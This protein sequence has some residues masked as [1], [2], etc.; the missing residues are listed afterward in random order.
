M[1]QDRVVDGM[2]V[3]AQRGHWLARRPCHQS[4]Y[5]PPPSNEGRGGGGET[6][7]GPDVMATACTLGLMSHFSPSDEGRS[8]AEGATGGPHVMARLDRTA[9]QQSFR[10]KPRPPPTHAPASKH[11]TDQPTPSSGHPLR[12]RWKSAVADGAGQSI[13]C[14]PLTLW[15]F[16]EHAARPPGRQGC[17][18]KSRLNH[19][20]FPGVP[21]KSSNSNRSEPV[22]SQLWKIP[23]GCNVLVQKFPALRPTLPK[24]NG[25]LRF[26]HG[27]PVYV[28]GTVPGS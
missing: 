25:G 28:D 14:D 13:G 19:R 10:E 4:I 15:Y 20:Y 7:G 5:R 26:D 27:C 9:G 1:G 21:G 16:H 17:H 3:T 18:P 2:P 8:G 22:R 23:G 6:L 12:C 24:T 11:L